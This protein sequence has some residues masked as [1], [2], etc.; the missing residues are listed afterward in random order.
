MVG[1][2]P[3]AWTN[4]QW[5]QG[6][7]HLCSGYIYRSD[8]GLRHNGSFMKYQTH[9]LRLR[10]RVNDDLGSKFGCRF[11]YFRNNRIG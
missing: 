5:V 9:T 11:R 8:K 2:S 10:P 7:G 6:Q 3:F 4:G 1:R